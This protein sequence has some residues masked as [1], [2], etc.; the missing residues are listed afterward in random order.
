[1]SHATAN[2]VSRYLQR[3]LC[4]DIGFD[5][6]ISFEGEGLLCFLIFLRV[7]YDFYHWY[8]REELNYYGKKMFNSKGEFRQKL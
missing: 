6:I 4:L 2:T 1:M 3:M 7:G 5:N 8:L